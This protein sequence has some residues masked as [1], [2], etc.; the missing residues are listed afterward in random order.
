MT[1]AARGEIFAGLVQPRPSKNEAYDVGPLVLPAKA[2][3]VV[4]AQETAP[5]DSGFPLLRGDS[6]S[7]GL[8]H[9]RP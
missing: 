2:Q 9:E 3:N 7:L 5:D 1:A 6:T 4:L 8:L